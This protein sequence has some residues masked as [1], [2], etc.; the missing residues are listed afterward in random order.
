MN[1]YKQPVVMWVLYVVSLCGFMGAVMAL[2]E[3]SDDAAF[4]CLVVGIL[5]VALAYAVN[6]LSRIAFV[7]E[8]LLM[9]TIRQRP[10]T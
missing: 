1:G 5:L 9:E 4:A 10:T 3:G 8:A 6:T 2:R 7:A